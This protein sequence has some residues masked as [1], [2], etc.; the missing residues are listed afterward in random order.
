MTWGVD[1]DPSIDADLY[2]GASHEGW[3]SFQ[4]AVDDSESLMTFGRK[5]DGTGGLWFKLYEA[6]SEPM[7]TPSPGYSRSNPV[8]ICVP[9]SIGIKSLGLGGEEESWSD[10]VY[11]YYQVKNT[12]PVHIGYYKFFYNVTCEDG[13]QYEDWTNG[14]DVFMDSTWLDYTMCQV[15][16]KVTSVEISDYEID[17]GYPSVVLYEITGSAQ[18]V[19]VTLS[20]ATG[21]TEQYSNVS[22]PKRYN[23]YSF[24]DPF[25]NAP[26]FNWR[27]G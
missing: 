11:I 19:D 26:R 6:N 12:G 27:A 7:P 4:V 14:S 10:Y 8:G 2:P 18:K 13:T 24:S 1:P 16:G 3:M 17:E 25:W 21:G 23:Y 5:Y 9:L 15:S 22:V 20:N